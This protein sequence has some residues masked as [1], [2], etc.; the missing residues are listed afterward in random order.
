M[1]VRDYQGTQYGEKEYPFESDQKF[2]WFD[3]NNPDIS[4]I[5]RLLTHLGY[6]T[7]NIKITPTGI[8]GIGI[9][10]DNL[11]IVIG[12][13]EEEGQLAGAM[14][15]DIWPPSDKRPRNVRRTAAQARKKRKKFSQARTSLGSFKMP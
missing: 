12:F 13:S 8:E 4:D 3:P 9:T 11:D 1:Y 7:E 15:A 10:G 5:E 6:G 14:P 2:E